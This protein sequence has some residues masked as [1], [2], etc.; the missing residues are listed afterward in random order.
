MKW[1]K[2]QKSTNGVLEDKNQS[3]IGSHSCIAHFFSF[4][5]TNT[6]RW[7]FALDMNKE[8]EIFPICSHSRDHDGLHKRTEVEDFGRCYIEIALSIKKDKQRM[9]HGQRD[10]Q[11]ENE[12]MPAFPFFFL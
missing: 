1:K 7:K 12:S 9:W 2:E 6:K 4:K 10:G 3:F 5:Q 11:E 8:M